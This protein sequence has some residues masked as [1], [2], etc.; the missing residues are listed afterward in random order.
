[1]GRDWRWRA[2]PAAG[3]GAQAIQL[4]A[5]PAGACFP[6]GARFDLAL[7]GRYQQENAVAALAAL[8]VAGRALPAVDLASAQAGLATVAWPG[9]L[10]WLRPRA[11]GPAVLLDVAHNRDSAEK[12]AASLRQDYAYRRLWL[13][14]GVM[15]DKDLA[16]ILDAQLPLAAGT[17]LTASSHP[18]ALPAEALGRAAAASGY[19][20]AVVPGVGQAFER[21]WAAAGPDDLICVAG[22]TAVVGDLLKQWETL[23]SH[24]PVAAQP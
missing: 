18:R 7:A 4:T 16:G 17:C 15:A 6:A 9:R 10:Q 8:D 24:L 22:S 12:L 23:Q 21:A 14:L 11:N 2:L 3:P 1:V 5:V 20:A 13:V 19:P